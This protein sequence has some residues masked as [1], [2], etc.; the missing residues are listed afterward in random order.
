M[1]TPPTGGGANRDTD[2]SLDYLYGRGHP[3][4]A[5]PPNGEQRHFASCYRC[6]QNRGLEWSQQLEKW[7]KE[8]R[9]K[10]K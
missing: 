4:R 7:E 8:K 1:T 9:S 6:N 5:M 2:C 10:G 3:M